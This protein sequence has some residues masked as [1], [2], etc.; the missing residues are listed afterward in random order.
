MKQ[1]LQ[2]MV[3]GSLI[4]VL[5]LG[6]TTVVAST[7]RTI[8]IRHGVTVTL[9]GVPQSFPDDMRPFIAE[10]RTFLPL[11]AIADMQG[12]GVE[13]DASTST[14]H[15]TSDTTATPTAIQPGQGRLIFEDEHVRITFAG[16]R[17]SPDFREEQQLQFFVE[18]KTASTLGFQ[19]RSLSINGISLG[20]VT[21]SDTVAPH[22]SGMVRFRTAEPFPTMNPSTVSG[23]I[24][25]F[26]RCGTTT[27][28]AWENVVL[29]TFTNISVD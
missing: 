15:L 14:A 10:E 20:S 26:D 17:I 8:E 23:T 13:W 11:R 5:L 28:R 27:G 25:V 18:N 7:T 22:S 1:R 21:G 29:V 2:G 19:S 16:T 24:D 4:T 3:I 9:D 6:T 12:L